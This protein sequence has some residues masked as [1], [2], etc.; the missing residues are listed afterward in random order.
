MIPKPS[1]L[2][3]RRNTLSPALH[4]HL[5]DLVT[6]LDVPASDISIGAQALD[7]LAQELA[8]IGVALSNT[9]CAESP[10]MLKT[11]DVVRHVDRLVV[12]AKAAA[13]VVELL[14]LQGEE[15][16]ETEETEEAAQ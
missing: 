13:A 5:T 15:T 11:E 8:V 6:G 9:N 1:A 10:L 16:E 2:G 12:R 14:E 4:K 3:H 7:S